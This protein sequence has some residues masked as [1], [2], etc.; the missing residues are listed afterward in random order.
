M[1]ERVL[2]V[3]GSGGI[4]S[5]LAKKLADAG[6]LPLITFAS[7]DIPARR[8][9]E[10]TGGEALHLNLTD[11]NSIAS[12]LEQIVL[13]GE[14]IAGVILAASPPPTVLPLFKIP[15]DNFAQQ[16]AVN[17]D[18]P[19]ILLDG[20]V[21]QCMRKQKKGWLVGLLSE[22]MGQDGDTA[23]SMGSYIIAKYGQLGLLKAIKADYP[24]L[25]VNSVSPN[26]T[27]TN[28][29]DAFDERFLDQMREQRPTGCFSTT[30][31]V[32]SEVMTIIG[33]SS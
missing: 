25:D 19:R 11:E 3:G 20:I 8:I 10:E 27:D 15:N 14:P 4:G 24:W 28:M 32:A 23:K 13:E 2:I 16:W 29:L 6:Y 22:A 26:F 12:V 5:A 33:K 21:R 7:H 1:N 9:A 30:D 18:G 31:E 17:V